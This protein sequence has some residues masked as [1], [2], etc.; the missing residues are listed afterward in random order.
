MSAFGRGHV[1]AA[2]GQRAAGAGHGRA[3]T[4][5]VVRRPAP[6]LRRPPL[7]YDR[8]KGHKVFAIPTDSTLNNLYTHYNFRLKHFVRISCKVCKEDNDEINLLFACIVDILE[9]L[10]RSPTSR[11]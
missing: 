4:S 10:K 6:D 8:T 2:S 3:V 7:R 11:R 5:A 9:A 1:L